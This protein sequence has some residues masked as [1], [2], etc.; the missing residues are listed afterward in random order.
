MHSA[1][2][3]PVMGTSQRL[4]PLFPYLNQTTNLPGR[5][6]GT[7][8][9][10]G[11]NYQVSHRRI[12]AVKSVQHPSLKQNTTAQ[13]WMDLAVNISQSENEVSSTQT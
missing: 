7:N 4:S 9:S 11:F 6:L 10:Q 2:L 1:A 13:L 12:T 8:D 5:K 3:L